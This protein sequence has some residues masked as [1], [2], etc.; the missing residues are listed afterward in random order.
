MVAG[1]P[2]VR[3]YGQ[4]YYS[5]WLL[6]TSNHLRGWNNIYFSITWNW[7]YE[8]FSQIKNV[9]KCY[10]NIPE[11]ISIVFSNGYCRRVICY[12]KFLIYLSSCINLSN[13]IYTILS[14]GYVNPFQTDI[15]TISDQ[16][17]VLVRILHINSNILVWNGS[18]SL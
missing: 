1:W 10:T 3:P 9:T 12:F 13:I 11:Q 18:I 5:F 2:P 14:S 8:F 17:V 7:T 4:P 16:T 6:V 15:I